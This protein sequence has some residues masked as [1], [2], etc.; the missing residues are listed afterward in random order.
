MTQINEEIRAILIKINEGRAS[1][2]EKARFQEWYTSFDDSHTKVEDNL[3]TELLQE[4]IW[5]EIGKHTA[6]P[7][8][9][10]KKYMTVA[11]AALLVI[12]S[13][14]FFFQQKSNR[15]DESTVFQSGLY[16]LNEGVHAPVQE[17][18]ETVSDFLDSNYYVDLAKISPDAMIKEVYT[19]KGQF[20]KVI[21]PDGTKVSLN[22]GTTLRLSP[23]FAASSQRTVE[24]EGEAYFEV[25]T[26][27][28]RSFVVK[29]K[30]QEVRV[31]GTKFNVKAY[32]NQSAIK[33]T[34]Y[35]GKIALADG[36]E[37]HVLAP[38]QQAINTNGKIAIE[39][40]TSTASFGWRQLNFEFDK[41]RMEDVLQELARWYKL[42]LVLESKVP[43]Q[44]ISGKIS[45]GT[46]LKDLQL[47]LTN[48]T[49][50]TYRLKADKLYVKFK[51]N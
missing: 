9:L 26:I 31:L 15:P 12:G 51:N 45:R 25:T 28:H 16:V 4:E 32:P 1:V 34:L 20:S 46:D 39:Q 47:I 18:T 37:T 6:K 38:K 44:L 49:Q 17:I 14:I 50:G 29:A 13:G 22:V 43:N 19:G 8:V 48:L 36:L 41:E 23:D 7:K 10:W 11:A 35:E 21:L 5:K 24:L 30:S 33:T 42:D 3:D 2:E 40:N 27:P